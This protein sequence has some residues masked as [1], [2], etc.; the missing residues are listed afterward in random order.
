M[1]WVPSGSRL[2][3][4]LAEITMIRTLKRHGNAYTIVF[5]SPDYYAKITALK[6]GIGVA[7]LP[8]G[9]IPS[10]LVEAKDYYLPELPPVKALLY[11]RLEF[12]TPKAK[13]VLRRLSKL[14]F[15]PPG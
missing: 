3:R 14:F 1:N 4:G 11:A 8:S 12:D 9:M 5:N 7:A 2:T 6:K 10:P 15:P 13:D